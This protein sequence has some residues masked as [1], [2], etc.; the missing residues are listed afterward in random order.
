[1]IDYNIP[2]TYKKL[3]EA[4]DIPYYTGGNQKIKQIDDLNNKYII[5]KQG[6]KYVVIREKNEQEL[7]DIKTN[8][9]YTT[10]METLLYSYLNQANGYKITTTIPKLI[11]KMCLINDNYYYGKYNKNKVLELISEEMLT[12]DNQ[13]NFDIDIFFS[14]TENNFSAKIKSLLDIMVDKSL[15]SFNRDLSLSFYDGKYTTSRLATTDENVIFLEIQQK[16]LEHYKKEDGTFLVKSELDKKQ[17]YGFYKNLQFQ[18]K[19]KL[20]CDYYSYQYEIIL[21]KNGIQEHLISNLNTLN[22]L[23]N[24]VNIKSQD[25]L[26]SSKSNYNNKLIEWFI[27]INTELNLK[28]K[29]KQIENSSNDAVYIKDSIHMTLDE[30]L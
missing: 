29:V 19:E 12:L 8:K 7:Q 17:R 23:Q 15:I 27:D 3:T 10:I 9:T 11:R 24:E 16:L 4:L 25:N 1:M 6:N 30:K 20:G 18:I 28:D 22:I 21:N 14:N 13:D 26:L 2:T 5:E